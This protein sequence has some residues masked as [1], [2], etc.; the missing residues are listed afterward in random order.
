M[1]LTIKHLDIETLH[2][3]FGHTSDKVMYYILNNVEDTK[4]I[5]FL[6]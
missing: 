2:Y 6:I 1:N 4:K 3:H 5:Y